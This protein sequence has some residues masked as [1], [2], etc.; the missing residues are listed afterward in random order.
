[1][2]GG[3]RGRSRGNGPRLPSLLCRR[4]LF[5]SVPVAWPVPMLECEFA[6]YRQGLG[7]YCCLADMSRLL[8][9]L[10]SEVATAQVS[11]E[12]FLPSS[13][14]FLNHHVWL[15]SCLLS[16]ATYASRKPLLFIFFP[17]L[18][19]FLSSSCHSLIFSQA[20]TFER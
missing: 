16:P 9:H 18:F 12:W 1:M 11:W 20:H 6:G 5:V 15:C 13:F 3:R 17:S 4:L 8:L 2:E 7:S 10:G 19:F 14:L